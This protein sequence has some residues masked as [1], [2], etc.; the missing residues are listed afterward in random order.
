MKLLTQHCELTSKVCIILKCKA[1]FRKC[2]RWFGGCSAIPSTFVNNDQSWVVNR[3]ISKI[4]IR[5]PKDAWV[6]L[7]RRTSS[8]FVIALSLYLWSDTLVKQACNI[9]KSTEVL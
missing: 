6:F 7:S 4:L 2:R 8:Q 9:M 1:T 5:Y 3:R